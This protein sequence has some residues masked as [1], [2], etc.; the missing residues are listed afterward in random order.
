MKRMK[1]LSR[2]H[3]QTSNTKIYFHHV[4]NRRISGL[5]KGPLLIGLSFS[6]SHSRYI[7]LLWS[8]RAGWKVE[9]LTDLSYSN[10]SKSLRVQSNQ[11]ARR[12]RL[13]VV[14]LQSTTIRFSP[15]KNGTNE[16]SVFFVT[17]R[18]ETFH[19]MLLKKYPSL[20]IERK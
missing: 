6:Q 10:E 17:N 16:N 3:G 18:L 5:K 15:N 11:E 8:T 20:R 2:W 7:S 1:I 14:V 9:D 4:L 19:R 12:S 13:L